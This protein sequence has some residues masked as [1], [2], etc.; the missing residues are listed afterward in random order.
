MAEYRIGIVGSGN[1]AGRFIS[2]VPYAKEDIKIEYIYNPRIKSAERFYAQH[3]AGIPTDDFEKMLG[4]A[5]IV[6]IASPHET[7]FAYSKKALLAGKHVLCEKPMTFKRS[8]AEEMFS[9]AEKNGLVLMEAIK[10][11]YCPGFIRL[12]ELVNSGII[13]DILDVDSSFVRGAPEESKI[14]R[15]TK[16]GGSFPELSSYT[17]LPIVRFLGTDDLRYRFE[18]LYTDNG[19]DLYTKAYFS[20]G[21]SFGLSKTG[22]G[23]EAE[24]TLMIT[25]TKGYIKVCPPWWHTETIEVYVPG[26]GIQKIFVPYPGDGLRTEIDEMTLR[27]SDPSYKSTGITPDESCVIAEIIEEYFRYR[28]SE[29]NISR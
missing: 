5:D 16:N 4:G 28:N 24:G 15:D 7:H 20:N 18:S 9:I 17:L 2:E 25:G 14:W 13:G 10:T 22:L 11:S 12:C 6:Y 27:I 8:E 3:G 29:S 19:I 23:G 1:I 21:R 26:E